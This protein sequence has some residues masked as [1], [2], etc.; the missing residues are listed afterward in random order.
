MTN[1][2]YT[3]TITPEFICLAGVHGGRFL[4]TDEHKEMH[5][6]ELLDQQINEWTYSIFK[7]KAPFTDET[8][9]KYLNNYCWG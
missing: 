4:T 3:D 1:G 5:R 7:K 2:R 9:E 6:I 8:T